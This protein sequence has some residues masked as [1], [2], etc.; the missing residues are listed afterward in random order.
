MTIKVLLADD[1]EDVLNVA[2]ASLAIGDR[3]ELLTAAD[4]Q[5]AFD[6]CV[7]EKPDLVL[8]DLLMPK[9][10]GITV[11]LDLRATPEIKDM[12]IVILTA[13]SQESDKQSALLAGADDFITKPFSP[14]E[15]LG[16][17]SQLLGLD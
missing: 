14:T 13:L 15:L 3:F 12:K 1:E 17:V 10:S 8:L 6:T 7:A 9:K 11:C 5:Q 2:K 4:G 16:K